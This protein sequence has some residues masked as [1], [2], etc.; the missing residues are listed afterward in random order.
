MVLLSSR[1]KKGSPQSK[2]ACNCFS[3]PTSTIVGPPRL[4][5]HWL[6][7]VWPRYLSYSA[8]VHTRALEVTDMLVA[9]G[10]PV[11]R[12]EFLVEEKFSG[13]V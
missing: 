12:R 6:N 2:S 1:R 3:G 5:R 7:T 10:G 13:G 4:G 8:R 9:H 11:E